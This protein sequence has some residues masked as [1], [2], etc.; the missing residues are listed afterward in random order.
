M[1][2]LTDDIIVNVSARKC[3]ACSGTMKY[4]GSGCFVCEKCGAEFLT[5]FGKVKRFLEKNGPSNVIEIYQATGVSRRVISDYLK[6]GRMEIVNDA[7]GFLHCNACG[8]AIRS[9]LYCEKCAKKF[10][11]EREKNR[12]LYNAQAERQDGEMRFRRVDKN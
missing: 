6:E 3:Q 8:V 2:D 7:S 11:A 5:D 1:S 10:A 4:K 12:N 9:G